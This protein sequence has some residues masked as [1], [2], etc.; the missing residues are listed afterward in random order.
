MTAKLFTWKILNKGSDISCVANNIEDARYKIIDA[1]HQMSDVSN[2]IE[3]I[4]EER[5][6]LIKEFH[7][8]PEQKE[9]M[10]LKI[11]ELD[12]KIINVRNGIK[13]NISIGLKPLSYFTNELS[14]VQLVNNEEPIVK[15]FYSV[16]LK[17]DE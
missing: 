6:E 16:T 13:V 9:I 3:S 11:V 17:R 5:R 4:N 12:E 8:T 2:T 7:S 1:I 15:E 14:L 10:R